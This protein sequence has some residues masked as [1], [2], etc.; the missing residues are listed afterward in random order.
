MSRMQPR[1]H[2]QSLSRVFAIPIVIAV[3]SIIGLVSALT[4][5]GVRDIISW[6]TLAVPIAAAGWAYH[7]RHIRGKS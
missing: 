3:L 2:R 1:K 4:G 5:D 6:L 7:H